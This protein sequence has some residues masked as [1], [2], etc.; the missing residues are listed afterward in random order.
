MLT[1]IKV[2]NFKCFESL[3]L[4]LSNLTLLTGFNTAGKSTSLQ[5]ERDMIQVVATLQAGLSSSEHQQFLQQL[6]NS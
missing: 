5:M 6:T 1:G 2:V 3:A 4:P